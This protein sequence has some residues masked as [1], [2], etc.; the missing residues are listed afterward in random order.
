MA[1]A[2][3][4]HMI[5]CPRCGA[6]F[7]VPASLAGRRARCD[8]CNEPFAVPALDKSTEVTVPANQASPKKTVPKKVPKPASPASSVQLTGFECRVCGT[9]LYGP[10]DKVGKK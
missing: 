2:E 9:R 5:A 8:G 6:R 3:P 10:P 7:A 4:R 1:A